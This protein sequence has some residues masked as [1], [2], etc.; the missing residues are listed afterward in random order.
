MD[1]YSKELA[2]LLIEVS[3]SEAKAT[4]LR[5]SLTNAQNSKAE[6]DKYFANAGKSLTEL[7]EEAKAAQALADAAAKARAEEREK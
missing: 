3:A 1:K 2:V 4:A 6:A 7:Y 5:N